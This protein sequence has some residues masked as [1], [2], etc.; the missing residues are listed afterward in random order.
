[1]EVDNLPDS[2]KTTLSVNKTWYIPEKLKNNYIMN[3][4][5]NSGFISKTPNY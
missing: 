1:M 5:K 2:M 4:A 3:M